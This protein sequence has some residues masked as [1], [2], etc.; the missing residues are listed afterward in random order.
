MFDTT[1]QEVVGY[2]LLGFVLGYFAKRIHQ[3]FW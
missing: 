3:I 1:L 2:L